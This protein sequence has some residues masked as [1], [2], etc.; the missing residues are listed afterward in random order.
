MEMKTRNEF[1][2][3][4]MREAAPARR[5]RQ[6]IQSVYVKGSVKRGRSDWDIGDPV[7]RS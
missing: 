6:N 3:L 7:R 5:V 1:A 2:D 4:V